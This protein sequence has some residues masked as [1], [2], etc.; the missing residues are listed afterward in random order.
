MSTL[1]QMPVRSAPVSRELLKSLTMRKMRLIC[2][3]RR[4]AMLL[5]SCDELGEAIKEL[6]AELSRDEKAVQVRLEAGA[7]IE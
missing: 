4:R 2:L 6:Q 3:R 5:K 7:E 1:L